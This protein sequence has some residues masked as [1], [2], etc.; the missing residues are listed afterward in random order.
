MNNLR[1]LGDAIV[2]VSVWHQQPLLTEDV[3]LGQVNIAL[4]TFDMSRSHNGWYQLCA[5]QGGGQTPRPD[6]GSLRIRVSYCEDFIFPLKVYAPLQ[7][8][9]L[10]SLTCQV[11]VAEGRSCDMCVCVLFYRT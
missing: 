5:R 10:N 8:S 7:T 3:F 1:E 9:L 4:T 2:R 6:V 11:G